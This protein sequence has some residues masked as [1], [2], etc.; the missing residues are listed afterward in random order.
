MK[1][2]FNL[3]RKLVILMKL[4]F[5][6][7]AYLFYCLKIRNLNG[8]TIKLLLKIKIV[9]QNYWNIAKFINNFLRSY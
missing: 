6:L 7:S 5:Y 2:L 8:F 4:I 1:M 3:Q 9:I